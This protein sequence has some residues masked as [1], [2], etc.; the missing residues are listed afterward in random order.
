MSTYLPPQ[1]GAWAFLGLPLLLGASVVSW[2]PLLLFLAV[3]WVAAYPL[4]YAALGLV[5]AKRPQ[6]FRRPFL[7]WLAVVLPAVLV[8]VVTRPWLTWVGLVYLAMF[9]VNLQYAK[10]NDE[11]DMVNELVFVAECSAIVS[12]MWSVGAGQ[13]SWT[14]PALDSVPDR[15]WIL[16]VVCMLV[17]V[18]STLH[19]KSLIRERRDPWFERASKVVAVASVLASVA[20]ALWWGW[21]GGVWLVVPFVVLSVRAFMVPGRSLRAGAIGMIELVGYVLVVVGSVLAVA[22]A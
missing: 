9:V 22:A 3:A 11:R 7:V 15:V 8:L 4:S 21:P 6:R 18:G 12:V 14:T 5:R 1:H 13:Q 17:L 20:L 10:R 2:T 19:V 16:T